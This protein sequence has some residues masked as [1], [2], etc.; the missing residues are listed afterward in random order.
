[1]IDEL[2][3]A[4]KSAGLSPNGQQSVEG[5]DTF[6]LRGALLSAHRKSA[7]S[8]SSLKR[9]VVGTQATG[10]FVFLQLNVSEGASAAFH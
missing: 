6:E 9:P 8:F 2:V 1:M 5:Y 7:R 10:L 3:A 4:A